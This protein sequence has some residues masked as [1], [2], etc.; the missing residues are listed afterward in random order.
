MA[1]HDGD[2]FWRVVR[3]EPGEGRPTT[4]Q[5]FLERMGRVPFIARYRLNREPTH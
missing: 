2:R 4:A 1:S 3:D 5:E